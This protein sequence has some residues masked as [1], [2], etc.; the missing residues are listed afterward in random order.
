MEAFTDPSIDNYALDG[1]F[2]DL[3]INQLLLY[4]VTSVDHVQSIDVFV[5]II[6]LITGVEVKCGSRHTI[7]LLHLNYM[8]VSLNTNKNKK[9]NS[10]ME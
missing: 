6:W 1:S 10:R 2:R 4:L 8:C 9:V 3:L 7:F 5:L